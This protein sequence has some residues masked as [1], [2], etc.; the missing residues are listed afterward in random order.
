MN[1]DD[2]GVIALNPHLK[3][4]CQGCLWQEWDPQT[5]Q[6]LNADNPICSLYRWQL[7]Y[8]TNIPPT[9]SGLPV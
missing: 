9:S 3:E 8:S 6:C 5:K 1:F 4:E 2:L 7:L